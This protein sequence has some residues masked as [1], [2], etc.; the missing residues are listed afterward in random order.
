V[1]TLL[2]LQKV[3]KVLIVDLDA[4]Q[5]NGL[6]TCFAHINKEQ[7]TFT[8]ELDDRV[9]ILDMYNANNYPND[10]FAQQFITFRHPLSP[11]TNDEVYLRTLKSSLPQALQLS[12]YD[13]VVYN[14]GTDVYRRDPLGRLGLT[15]KG[16]IERDAFVFRQCREGAHSPGKVNIMMVLSGGYTAESAEIIADSIHNLHKE[17][18]ICLDRNKQS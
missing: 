5:G 9:H 2:R 18:L 13:L 11:K 3:K 4:H 8:Y 17:G 7:D 15:R 6:I 12:S 14:A 1:R 10:S 16:I